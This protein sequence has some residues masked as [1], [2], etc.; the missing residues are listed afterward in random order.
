ML[1]FKEKS[2]DHIFRLLYVVRNAAH[3]RSLGMVRRDSPQ[4]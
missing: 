3:H 2:S 1:N 4:G